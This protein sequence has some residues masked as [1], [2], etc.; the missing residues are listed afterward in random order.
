MGSTRVLGDGR[1]RWRDRFVDLDGLRLHLL[2]AGLPEAET[3]LLL[4]GGSA[5][6][7]WWDAAA[8]LLAPRFHVLALDL[9]GHG[10]SSHALPPSY[11]WDDYAGDLQSLVRRLGLPRLHLV[12]HSLGG[13]IA[14]AF[15]V[16]N[17]KWLASLTVVDAQLR[18]SSAAVRYLRRLALLPS[19]TYADRETALER[20][21]L[22]PAQT[23]ADP[24]LLR[25]MAEHAYRQQPDGSW[26]LK[27]DRAALLQ[28]EPLDLR[29][30]LAALDIPLLLMRGERSTVVSRERLLSLRDTFP[31]ARIAEVA[32]AHHHVMLD[33]PA[34]FASALVAFLEER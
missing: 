28:V 16:R 5:H 18:F 21:R 22:L 1:V 23:D 32:G 15:A 24:A 9:R 27:V 11:R 20:F 33:N 3:V 17:A 31:A 19:P 12:G 30:E 25:C 29:P 26:V 7:H 2:M 6:A 13:T 34:G 8:V 10:D 4:H 14:A